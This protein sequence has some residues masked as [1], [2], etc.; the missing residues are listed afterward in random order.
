MWAQSALRPYSAAPLPGTCSCSVYP[1]PQRPVPSA[2]PPPNSSSPHRAARCCVQARSSSRPLPCSLHCHQRHWWVLAG[3]AAAVVGAGW[4]RCGSGGC[5]VR[6]WLLLLCQPSHSLLHPCLHCRHSPGVSRRRCAAAGWA[7]PPRGRASDCR[8]REVRR[9]FKADGLMGAGRGDGLAC[10]P[11][12]P[13]CASV[14]PRLC[15]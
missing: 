1:L 14:V 5:W 12:H 4:R 15:R 7:A 11:G 2:T 13:A 10:S 6:R 9:D 3:G 8:V